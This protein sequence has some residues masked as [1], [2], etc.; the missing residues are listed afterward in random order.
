MDAGVPDGAEG[1]EEGGCGA[2]ERDAWGF[3]AR[4]EGRCF[5]VAGAKDGLC[6]S[7][8]DGV[9]VD[10]R[11]EGRGGREE[12]APQGIVLRDPVEV[13][14]CLADVDEIREGDVGQDLQDELFRQ[15]QQ[16]SPIQDEW[17]HCP[18]HSLTH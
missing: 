11:G 10:G 14:A 6:Q 9:E 4:E 1:G 12:R 3:A 7:C 5:V 18:Q 8:L 17:P 13:G 16:H 2:L 15:R